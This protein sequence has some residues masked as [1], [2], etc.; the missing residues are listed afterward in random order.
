MSRELRVD[1]HQA[2]GGG[3][4]Q[5]RTL[6]PAVGGERDL[7]QQ[8]VQRCQLS[9][10][11][12]TLA[13][14]GDQVL[15]TVERSGLGVRRRRVKRAP[16]PKIALRGQGDRAL[17]KR[18]PGGE[19][20]AGSSPSSAT[21]EL[22][23]HGL[24]RAWRA[25]RA[26]PGAAVRIA[27][28]VGLVGEGTVSAQTL[29]RRSRAIDR[30]THEGMTEAEARSE[31]DQVRLHG[32]SRSIRVDPEPLRR[33][34]D[35]RRVT[36]RVSRG[37]DQ[38]ALRLGRQRLEPAQEALLDAAREPDRVR[39]AEATRELRGGEP[40]RQLQKR[41]R[42]PAGL[43][44]DPVQ[45]GSVKRAGQRRLQQGSSVAVD[46]AVEQELRQAVEPVGRG[47]GREHECH[48]VRQQAT[49]DEGQHLGRPAVQPL[50]VVDEQQQRLLLSGF[51]EQP[52]N[53]EADDEAVRSSAGAQA[54]R[55]LERRTLRIGQPLEVRRQR[56]AH[57]MQAGERE[58]HLG[59]H[60]GCAQRVH[61]IG[62][63]PQ[64]LQQRGLPHSRLA[65]HHE[66]GTAARANGV[67]H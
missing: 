7:C 33:S 24:V 49:G 57:L 11:D 8:H 4:Q 39:R 10:V 63:R 44:H 15:G 25:L 12:R 19:S 38:Q 55:D 51:G 28:G 60:T 52:E 20:A 37:D 21:C 61:A 3:E 40:A 50:R 42:V 14:D 32:R 54:E 31:L 6:G 27:F 46:E 58:L 29:L 65:P 64:V 59:L 1:A 48:R 45:H 18:G 16:R 53:P 5:A 30:R 36:Q 67:E 9:L 47:A 2:I 66:R 17:E 26:M 22:G 13:C 56:R 41:Q 34:P 23:G 62:P 43:D 35:E